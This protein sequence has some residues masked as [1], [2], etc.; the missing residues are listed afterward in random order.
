[1]DTSIIIRSMTGLRTTRI[2][3]AGTI[4]NSSTERLSVRALLRRD[5]RAHLSD[6][7]KMWKIPQTA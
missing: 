3:G 5:P 4:A 6:S 7:R 1:M 2:A